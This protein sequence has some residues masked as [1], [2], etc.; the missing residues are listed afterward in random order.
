MSDLQRLREIAEAATPGPWEWRDEFGA[1]SLGPIHGNYSG[2]VLI[3]NADE[4]YIQTF[5]PSLVKALLDVAE[6]AEDVF[7]EQPRVHDAQAIRKALT[8]LRGKMEGK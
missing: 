1:S 2:V 6:A 3:N 4:Q 7:G 5:N 8:A